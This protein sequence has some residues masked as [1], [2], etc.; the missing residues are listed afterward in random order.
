MLES[1]YPKDQMWI[2]SEDG[3]MLK[4]LFPGA[5]KFGLCFWAMVIPPV[6]FGFLV[7][8]AS[9]GLGWQL[10]DLNPW[11]S[12]NLAFLKSNVFIQWV[13]QGIFMSFYGFFGLFG[14]TPLMCGL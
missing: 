10:M 6:S 8:G 12:E 4:W 11:T 5:R 13:P 2:R 9:S 7:V 1:M 3:T 14:L